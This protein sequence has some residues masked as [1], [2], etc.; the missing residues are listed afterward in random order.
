MFTLDQVVPWGRSLD[1]YRSMFSLTDADLDTMNILGCADGPAS[2]N[3]EATRRGDSITSCDP[4]YQFN[5][6]EM[7]QRISETYDKIVDETRKNY[8]DFVWT[9]IKSV[10]ELGRRRMAAMRMFLDDYEMGKEEGRYIEASLPTLPFVD[11]EFDLA[12]CSHFLFLYTAQLGEDF[13]K[14]AIRELCR[15]AR[16]VRVFPLL[17]LGGKPSPFVEPVAA[18]ARAAGHEVLIERVPYEFQRGGNKMMRIRA[19]H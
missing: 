13:H 6:V 5:V 17:A 4:I 3:A 9:T 16:E 10:D 15:V 1:E 12:L 18:A 11:A 19:S 14:A 2:F 8:D 7:R